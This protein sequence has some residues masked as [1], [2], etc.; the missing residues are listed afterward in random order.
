MRS[1]KSVLIEVKNYLDDLEASLKDISVSVL[2]GHL[3]RVEAGMAVAE[4]SLAEARR[5]VMLRVSEI[6]KGEG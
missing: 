4:E 3:N 6:G 2:E 5:V 1:E